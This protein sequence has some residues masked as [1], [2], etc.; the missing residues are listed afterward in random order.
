MDTFN[1]VLLGFATVLEPM[2]LLFCLIGVV[3]GMIIGVLPGLG[4][5]ATIAILLPVTYSLEPTG[6]IIMLAGIFYGAI[7]GGTITAVLLRLPGEAASVVTSLDGYPMARQG[8]GG[9]AMTVA[10]VASFIGGTASIIVLTLIAPLISSVAV[11]FGPPEFAVLTLIGVALVVSVGSGR[12]SKSVAAAAFGLILATV[13]RD[14]LS[15]ESRFTFGSL[16]LIDG[17][18]FVIIAMGVFGLA[19]ILDNLKAKGEKPP[20]PIPITQVR[21]TRAET[22]QMVGPIARGGILGFFLGLLPGGGATL[23]ALVSYATERSWAKD[24][25]RFGRGAIEGVAGPETANNAAATSSF[26]PLLTL[27]I[28]ANPAMAM[29]FGAFLVVGVTP[30]P[31]LVNTDPELFWGVI[32]SMYIGNIF[33]IIMAIPLVGVFIK[34]LSI[35]PSYLAA[36]CVMVTVLGVFSLRQSPTDI[37]W[38]AVFG[39]LGYAMKNFGFAPGPLVLAFILGG[40]LEPAF[41]QS[42]TLFDGNLLGFATR[43][44]SGSLLAVAVLTIAALTVIRL[45]RRS[46]GP[47][48][49]ETV[50]VDD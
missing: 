49:S 41:R 42:M 11:S 34:V 16:E 18:D 33:L 3:V 14:E 32:N 38:L 50:L 39:A 45:R 43:P 26:I 6:A 4:P 17:F 44:I 23:S 15:G 13:G 47:V 48:L 28:P 5:S 31:N 37:I 12:V 9:V 46:R 10:A 1:D 40:I 35:K 36:I 30:G 24:K 2:N 27:G 21:P 22:K 29:L 7:Y 25:S 19:E 20:A 8:R